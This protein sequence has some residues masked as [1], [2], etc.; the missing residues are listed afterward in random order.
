MLGEVE[1]K[2]A[3]NGKGQKGVLAG[4]IYQTTISPDY[5]G[6]RSLLFTDP[7]DPWLGSPLN[8]FLNTGELLGFYLP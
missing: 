5:W 2:V 7:E 4:T 1:W 8:L 3:K 6:T